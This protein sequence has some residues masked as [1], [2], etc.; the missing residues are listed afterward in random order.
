MAIK[1]GHASIDENGNGRNGKAGDQ[2]SKE[3]CIRTWYNKGWTVVLRPK[4]ANIAEKSA[5]ACEAGCA[6]N[7]IGYDMNQRNTAHTQAIAVKYNLSLI[8]TPCE[9]DCSAFMT[10]CAIAG[11]VTS[12]EYT[13][14]APTTS[15][16]RR[17]FTESGGYDALTDTKYL[18][19]DEYLKRGDILVAEGHHTVMVLENGAKVKAKTATPTPTKTVE[20][21]AKEIINGIGGWGNDPERTARLKAA[22]YDSVAVQDRVNELSKSSTVKYYK[23]YTGKSESIVEALTVIGIDSSKANRKKIAA[24]NGISGYTGSAVQNMKLLALLKKGKLVKV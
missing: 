8:K 21:V 2:N 23:K 6:N 20:E 11:G 4:K 15:T 24:A 17:A 13:G 10:I 3:V 14:N 18:T 22:G 7:N 5:L 19:S 1:I 16:M 9:T 12:L